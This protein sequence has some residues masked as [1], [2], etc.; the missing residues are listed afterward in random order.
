MSVSTV[1]AEW[2]E[3]WTLPLAAAFGYATAVLHTYGIGAFFEPVQQEFGWTRGFTS[4][5]LTLAGV[6]AAIFSIPIGMLVDR[7]GPRPIALI[8]V[9]LMTAAFALLGTATGTTVNWF[10][11]WGFIA[12][13]NLWLQSTVW[14]SAVATRFENS[15]GL[16][17]AITMS[18]A[19]ISQ[20]ILP[21]LATWLVASYGW[22]TG[23]VAV[24]AIWFALVFPMLFLF[25]RG[26]RDV[27]TKGQ[28]SGSSQ[29]EALSGLS[30]P[31]GLRSPA[32]Y[33]L[34]VASGLFA[35][36]AIGTIVHFVPILREAGASPAGAAAVAGLV[37]IFS[38]IGRLGT[39]FLLDR[40]PGH[41]VG[42]MIFTFPIIAAALL[43][44]D[45]AD[46]TSQAVAA[47]IFG[48]TVGGEV[49]V[50]GYLASRH[51]GLKN[52][53]VLFGALV[54]ALALGV[55]FGPLAAGV[56]YDWYGGYAEFLMLTIGCMAVG[57][58][59]VVTLGRPRFGALAVGPIGG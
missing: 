5:G 37:G 4:G 2:R 1:R 43:L 47:S 16:A 27:G 21:I 49:D 3:H 18:G 38:L 53:G 58:L 17:F 28:A 25:F 50:I 59:A 40:F 45:G 56:A 13:A 41:L 9:V 6:V 52:F 7:L 20:M 46:P 33:Q 19:S 24:G 14:T 12:F 44:Y 36:T 26:A 48:L 35:F 29:M 57:A 31:E 11:L 39:G 34:L 10:V 42:A 15:R 54:G 30:V 32:F 22:R 55:A 23:F 51:F 8:G